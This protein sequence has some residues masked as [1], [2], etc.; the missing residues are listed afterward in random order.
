MDVREAPVAAVEYGEMFP[1][2][3]LMTITT[4]SK[5][6]HGVDF[7]ISVTAF[8]LSAFG[9]SSFFASTTALD[10]PVSAVGSVIPWGFC[11]VITSSL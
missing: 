2:R 1:E 5:N 7:F 9:F 11:N 6:P 3:T 8:G 4:K 10:A